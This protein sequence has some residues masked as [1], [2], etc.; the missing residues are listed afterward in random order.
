MKEIL[1][2]IVWGGFIFIL[3]IF[4]R[5]MNETQVEKHKENLEK[6]EEKLKNKEKDNTT[7]GQD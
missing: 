3:F 5:G 4:L 7:K 6:S 1:D 2:I